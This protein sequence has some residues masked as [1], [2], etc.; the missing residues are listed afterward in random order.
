MALD[1]KPQRSFGQFGGS[2]KK[3]GRKRGRG[4]TET[5]AEAAAARTELIIFLVVVFF[6]FV[7]PSSSVSCPIRA[8]RRRCLPVH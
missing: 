5:A 8:P 3:F 2:G 4:A 6:F 1:I 7:D